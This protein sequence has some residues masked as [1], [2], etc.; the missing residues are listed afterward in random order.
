M[1][2][3]MGGNHVSFRKYETLD[4]NKAKKNNVVIL[5]M[6]A[7]SNLMD[8]LGLNQLCILVHGEFVESRKIMNIKHK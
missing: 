6:F 7:G 1:C 8:K 4:Q 2:V 3:F 5:K